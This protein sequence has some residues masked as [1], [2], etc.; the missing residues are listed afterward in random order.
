MA[1]VKRWAAAA[2]LGCVVIAFAYLPPR[3]GVSTKGL[4][5]FVNQ[6]PQGTAARLR[7]QALADEWRAADGALRLVQERQRFRQAVGAAPRRGDTAGVTVLFTS[8]ATVSPAVVH[9]VEAA[10]D[11]AW[12]QLGLGETKVRVAAVIEL[13]DPSLQRDEFAYLE[14]DS[15]DRTTCIAFLPAGTFWSRVMR[16]ER[17]AGTGFGLVQWLQSGLGPCAFYAAYGTPGKPVRRWLAAR[18]WDVALYLDADRRGPDRFSSVNVL[19]DPRFRWFWESIYSFPPATV[20]CLAGRSEGCRAAVRA[21]SE[22]D[23]D[24]PIPQVLRMERR[25]WRKQHL[26][27]GERYLA[28]VKQAVGRERFLS[29]WTTGLT[30]D[31]AL[32]VA[33]KQPVG[34]W[35]SEWERRFVPRIRLG[36]TVSIV[37]MILALLVGAIAVT[38]VTLSASRR[39]VR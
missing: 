36:P 11:T 38:A 4:R 34:E 20:A 25:W 9:I 39:Q 7:A 8:A 19:G 27:P 18:S 35:T 23:G 1:S 6:P 14:P 32:T 30:V 16:R 28:D 26:L 10:M 21:G 3:G 29:F 31:S 24:M 33:L 12:R 2:V 15:T 17:M 5:L 37:A 22:T 13:W